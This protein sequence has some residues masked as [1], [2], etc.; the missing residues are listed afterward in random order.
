M[1]GTLW[2]STIKIKKKKLENVVKHSWEPVHFYHKCFLN[3][4]FK[5]AS[6]ADVMTSSIFVQNQ[7]WPA[8][9]IIASFVY[10][11]TFAL[12]TKYTF[13]EK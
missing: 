7:F 4:L 2:T 5:L 10:N 6:H 13:G 3:N 11:I 1:L 8:M 12:S 9:G